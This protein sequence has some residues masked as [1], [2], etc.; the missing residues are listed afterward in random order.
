MAKRVGTQQP[1][2]STKKTRSNKE[3]NVCIEIDSTLE[4]LFTTTKHLYME[5]NSTR[6][7]LF[8]HALCSYFG[9]DGLES[10]GSDTRYNRLSDRGRVFFAPNH[11]MN[12]PNLDFASSVE[13][14][15]VPGLLKCELLSKGVTAGSAVAQMT[16]K[17]R[18][19]PAFNGAKITKKEVTRM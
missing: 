8:E 16:Q 18:T 7:L 11:Q 15:Q 4:G 10:D 5:A 14:N 19:L 13:H 2:Q 6:R 1:N 9:N 3:T 17:A 12:R